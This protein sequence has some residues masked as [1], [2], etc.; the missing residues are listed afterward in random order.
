M[1]F[2]FDPSLV[3]Y[4]PLHERD[5]AT[6]YS[7]E[8]YGHRATVNGAVW[9]AQGMNFDG[10]DDKVTLND[11]VIGSPLN[12]TTGDFTLEFWV[13]IDVLGPSDYRNIISRGVH[14]TDGYY[15]DAREND[16]LRFSTDR[17]GISYGINFGGFF[18]AGAWLHGAVTKSGGSAVIY[19][20]GAIFATQG[21][22]GEPQS[23]D[24][25]TRTG[26]YGDGTSNPMDGTIG[27]VRVYN[28][29]LSALEVQHNYLATKWRYQ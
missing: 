23:N 13:N 19:R 28:R 16:K 26:I 14:E 12:F 4:L 25:P 18:S 10:S 15:V 29:A 9:T 3:L 8:G 1:D 21:G 22:Y 11:N 7:K 17:A 20:N 2:I 6:L 24:R 5:G 27:E